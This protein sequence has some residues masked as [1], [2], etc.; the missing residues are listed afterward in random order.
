MEDFSDNNEDNRLSKTYSSKTLIL[1]NLVS[2]AV[3][4]GIHYLLAYNDH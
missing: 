3:G 4:L 1:T 2:F